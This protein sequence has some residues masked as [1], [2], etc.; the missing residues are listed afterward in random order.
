M[1]SSVQESDEELNFKSKRKINVE[2]RR[3][4]DD[5]NRNLM[6]LYDI[7]RALNTKVCSVGRKATVM[8]IGNISAGKSTLINWILQENVQK[9]GMAIETCGITYVIQGKQNNDIGGETALLLLPELREVVKKNPSLLMSLSV[10]T[11][12]LNSIRFS[13]INFIDTPGLSDGDSIYSFDIDGVLRDI[14]EN[15]CDLILV[16]IDSTGNALS[17]RLI[18]ISRYLAENLS[19]KTRFILTKIDEIPTEEDRVKVMCQVTQNLTSKVQMKHGFD[20]IPIF[21]PGAKDGSY[22]TN[23]KVLFEGHNNEQISSENLNTSNVR[24]RSNKSNSN[25]LDKNSSLNTQNLPTLNRIKDVIIL[26]E[27][28]VD[29]KVQ[30]DI[31]SLLSDSSMLLKISKKL[32]KEQTEFEKNKTKVSRQATV[33]WSSACFVLFICVIL[34]AYQLSLNFGSKISLFSALFGDSGST[35]LTPSNESHENEEFGLPKESHK[36]MYNGISGI[37]W[38]ISLLAFIT[39]TFLYRNI[40]KEQTKM[41]PESLHTFRKYHKILKF[42]QLRAAEIYK[43]YVNN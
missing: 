12:S 4:A 28:I 1:S 8:V 32:I 14:A 35:S 39:L 6:G 34:G 38:F 41:S 24:A 27:K 11:C 21:V 22:L 20:L 36:Q 31:M 33:Y 3:T 26:V 13:N 10:K 30:N 7:G 16:C 15:I 37:L 25:Y 29:R 19:S 23:Y 43:L 5:G 42:T 2:G 17:K 40:Q 9:T 18:E